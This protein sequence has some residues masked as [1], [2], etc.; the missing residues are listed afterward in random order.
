MGESTVHQDPWHF[1]DA[2]GW[3]LLCLD[4][5]FLA[6]LQHLEWEVLVPAHDTWLEI[7]GR[8]PQPSPSDSDCTWVV[9]PVVTC[10]GGL[11][12]DPEAWLH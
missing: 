6:F 5:F 3:L 7:V 9:S 10:Q 2:C 12:R 11:G 1:E 4:P 8:G